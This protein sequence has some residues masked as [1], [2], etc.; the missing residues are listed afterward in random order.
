MVSAGS[1][2]RGAVMSLGGGVKL[3]RESCRDEEPAGLLAGRCCVGRDSDAPLFAT[4]WNTCEPS[5]SRRL[6]RIVSRSVLRSL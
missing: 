4:G 6:S 2:V 1:E 3:R 5:P